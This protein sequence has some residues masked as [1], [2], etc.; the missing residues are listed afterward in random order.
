MDNVRTRH[1]WFGPYPRSEHRITNPNYKHGHNPCC[2]CS[3]RNIYPPEFS[4]PRRLDRCYFDLAHVASDHN[5]FKQRLEFKG[6]P[7]E[8]CE[9]SELQ[10]FARQRSIQLAETSDVSH[11]QL[12]KT[13][14][15]ADETPQ[16][17]R[18][19]DLPAELRVQIYELY[20]SQFADNFM[21]PPTSPSLART[22]RQMRNKIMPVFYHECTFLLKIKRDR[23]YRDTAIF[24]ETL[25]P[26]HL[27]LIR[28][29]HILYSRE[30]WLHGRGRRSSPVWAMEIFLARE[31][32]QA[33]T[34]AQVIYPKS[35][36]SKQENP[37]EKALTNFV[38]EIEK[39][40][41]GKDHLLATD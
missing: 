12:A 35:R 4:D 14:R 13:L 36:S 5:Y 25:D 30:S 23:A 8:K 40:G 27:A 11:E 1:P 6:F 20:C 22:N 33:T 24:F 15:R 17:N 18:F 21:I 16:F 32:R 31:D 28:N 9:Q 38:R 39:R 3:L 10:Q 19:F 2:Y 34:R 29:L 41:P 26:A 37:L 7:Y